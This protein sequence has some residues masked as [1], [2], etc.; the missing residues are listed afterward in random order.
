MSESRIRF[1]TSLYHPEAVREA[2]A[3][4]GDVAKLVVTEAEDE[5]VVEIAT[6]D[7]DEEVLRDAFCNHALYATIQR[8]SSAP[9][10]GF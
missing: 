9:T 7:G 10:E 2:A 6:Y 1:A 3:A 5:I 4:Y 8:D